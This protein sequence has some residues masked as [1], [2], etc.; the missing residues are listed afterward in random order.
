MKKITIEIEFAGNLEALQSNDDF[1]REFPTFTALETH[2]GEN[3]R[4][5]LDVKITPISPS[6]HPYPNLEFQNSTCESTDATAALRTLRLLAQLEAI[7]AELKI[8]GMSP[9]DSHNWLVG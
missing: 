8:A 3:L 9:T 5:E 4:D 6:S 7:N 1:I 2:L